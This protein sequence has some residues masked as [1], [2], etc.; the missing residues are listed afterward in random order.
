MGLPLK[1][2]AGRSVG[3]ICYKKKCY[4]KNEIDVSSIRKD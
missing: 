4:A 3:G 1:L 2:S